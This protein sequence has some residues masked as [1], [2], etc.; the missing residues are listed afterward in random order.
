[1]LKKISFT[2][3]GAVRV[4]VVVVGSKGLRARPAAQHASFFDDGV[5]GGSWLTL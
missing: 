1:M 2:K 5:R 4:G 3:P